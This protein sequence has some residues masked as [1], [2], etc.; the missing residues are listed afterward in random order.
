RQLR[1]YGYPPDKQEE[2]TKLVLEQAT[3][4]SENYINE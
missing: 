4:I 3:L 2:A 1:K